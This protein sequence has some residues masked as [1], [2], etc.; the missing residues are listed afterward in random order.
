MSYAAKS[1]RARRGHGSWWRSLPV[2][3]TLY[4]A[5]ILLVALG[6][7]YVISY[8]RVS[9]MASRRVD[10]YLLT[11][12]DECHHFFD[13]K[14]LPAVV[15]EAKAE[16]QAEGLRDLYFRIMGD[17]GQTVFETA[18]PTLGGAAGPA[19]AAVRTPYSVAG[20]GDLPARAIVERLSP[21]LSLMIVASMERDYQL[22]SR[23]M[24]LI[25]AVMAGTWVC[26][27]AAGIAITRAHLRGIGAVTGAAMAI[28]EGSIE[29]RA[30]HSGRG[31]EIDQLAEAFN[32]MAHRV[33]GLLN[34]LRETN[35]SLAHELR[36]PLTRMRSRCELSLMH[37]QHCPL[38]QDLIEQID[39]L[40]GTINTILNMSVYE[41]GTKGPRETIDLAGLMEDACDLFLPV[42]EDRGI[43]LETEVAGALPVA[44]NRDQLQ[45]LFSNLL[46]NA[47][48]Y[49]PAGG[50]VRVSGEVK[51]GCAQVV[52]SD[53]GLGIAPDE[54]A[55]VFDRF[56]RGRN[57]RSHAGNGLGL[58]L[59]QVI[60]KSHG[61]KISVESQQQEGTTFRVVL[62][63]APG[64]MVTASVAAALTRKL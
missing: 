50:R 52:V 57:S 25:L 62:P 18:S 44:G 55:R 35:D 5:V 7:C 4:Y 47:I 10:A 46:D 45:R 1:E 2:R 15:E 14:G 38:A 12:S 36:S 42:A 64:G 30:P 51:E 61:G 8:W 21:K 11:E 29:R 48:K 20:S 27:C 31:D 24:S 40:L 34:N 53:T 13:L 3:L 49:T 6:V 58:S 26:A 63:A 60:A 17:R 23:L 41:S 28:A 19:T 56:Y 22:V 59:A 33:E 16:S 37:G 54:L 9:S 32:V 39:E 43:V